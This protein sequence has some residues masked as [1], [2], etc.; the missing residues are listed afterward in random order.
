MQSSSHLVQATLEVAQRS[1]EAL[2]EITR[3]IS[4]INERNMMIASATEQ[5]A[6]VAR[7]VD[8]NLV[9]IR[10]LSEQIMLG[11]EHTNTAGQELAQMAGTLHQTVVRFKI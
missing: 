1:G 6:L 5:Q 8:R 4:Q 10:N 11:A 2:E 9:G 3:S 7:E